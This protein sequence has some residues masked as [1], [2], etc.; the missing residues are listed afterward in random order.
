MRVAASGCCRRT[1]PAPSTGLVL[2]AAVFAASCGG[3]TARRDTRGPVVTVTQI[4]SRLANVAVVRGPAGAII[5]DSGYAR[6]AERIGAAIEAAGVRPDDVRAVIVTHGHGDHAGGAPHLAERFNAEIWAGAGDRDLLAA[7]TNVSAT[8]PELCARG[9]IAKLRVSGDAAATYPSISADIWVDQTV[10]LEPLIGAPGSVIPLP[11]HTDGSLIVVAGSFAF[12]GDL[13]RGCAL[14]RCAALHL[15][16]CDL[17]D[18]RRDIAALLDVHAPD[19]VRFFTGHF[20][21]LDR[22]AV[23]RLVESFPAEERNSSQ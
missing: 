8:Q 21:P 13:F 20:G 5:V 23:R 18:N 11:G 1:L 16:M 17:D 15:Y 7:G 4:E 14:G 9:L 6:D 2:A 12:V 22:P 19:A 10:S 3:A